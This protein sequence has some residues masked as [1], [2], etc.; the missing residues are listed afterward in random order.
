MTLVP[1]AGRSPRLP[2]LDF[3][4]P[5]MAEKP[6]LLAGSLSGVPAG[7]SAEHV[8]IQ[9]DITI[10]EDALGQGLGFATSDFACPSE[11]QSP[12]P[13]LKHCHINRVLLLSPTAL[14]CCAPVEHMLW[15]HFLLPFS[16]SRSAGRF[17]LPGSHGTQGRPLQ[18]GQPW[19]WPPP[20]VG[21]YSQ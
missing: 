17:P 3:H 16:S 6:W 10:Q 12:S 15:G 9:E 4:S 5:Q 14:V 20:R 21:G 7:I 8:T 11:H 19:A 2:A 1:S 18:Q 13:D